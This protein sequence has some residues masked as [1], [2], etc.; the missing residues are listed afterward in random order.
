MIV[1]CSRLLQSIGEENHLQSIVL[2]H[3]QR[4]SLAVDYFKASR[5]K[6]LQTTGQNII[7][8]KTADCFKASTKKVPVVDSFIVSLKTVA[9]HRQ[10]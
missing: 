2:Q 5:R 9:F 7:L 6:R 10:L 4:Q 1:H 8:P 3:S